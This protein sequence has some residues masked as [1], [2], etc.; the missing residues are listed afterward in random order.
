MAQYFIYYQGKQVGPL[1]KQDLLK[2]GLNRDSYVWV[3]GTP[4]WVAASTIPE[5]ADILPPHL[6]SAREHIS[7][8]HTQLFTMK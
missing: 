7:R 2:Y 3:V 6:H 1:E 4:S 8:K 5:L